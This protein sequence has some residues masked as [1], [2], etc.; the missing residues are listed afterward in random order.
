[1]P[2]PTGAACGGAG[3]AELRCGFRP[4]GPCGLPP[5]IP[6]GNDRGINL[7][8]NPPGHRLKLQ[9]RVSSREISGHRNASASTCLS[10]R[11]ARRKKSEGE[12]GRTRRVVLGLRIAQA[13]PSPA[14]AETAA[15]SALHSSMV[16][17]A[18]IRSILRSA[19]KRR[20][21]ASLSG[22]A[23]FFASSSSC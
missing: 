17:S 14:A 20:T 3:S 15:S 6:D 13:L 22:A 23:I 7:W 8:C 10:K 21:P 18:H 5:G 9:L 19:L 11:S 2:V 1:M 12:S 16:C 4:L